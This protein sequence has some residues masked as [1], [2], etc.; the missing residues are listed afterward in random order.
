MIFLIWLCQNLFVEKP[1]LIKSIIFQ[2]R[3]LIHRGGPWLTFTKFYRFFSD[4]YRI[5][6]LSPYKKVLLNLQAA[7]SSLLRHDHL[8]VPVSEPPELCEEMVASPLDHNT[9]PSPPSP[10]L[11]SLLAR[12]H[13]KDCGARN[14][15]LIMKVQI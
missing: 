13:L 4:F 11:L 1:T 3:L 2:K 6:Q 8:T 10:A 14:L 12:F 15:L 5:F 9:A 7:V